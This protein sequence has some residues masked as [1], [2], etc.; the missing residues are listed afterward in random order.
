MRVLKETVDVPVLVLRGGL[1][2]VW[3]DERVEGGHRR[4]AGLWEDLT[5][6]Q[7]QAIY[8]L[9]VPLWG[10][11][12]YLRMF[13]NA[14]LTNGARALAGSDL[15]A[16]QERQPGWL[17]RRIPGIGAV[18]SAALLAEY[19]STEKV[20]KAARSGR[21]AKF[22]GPALEKAVLKALVE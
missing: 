14:I 18:K 8:L 1:D 7:T 22:A 10:Y 19:G 2:P 4:P 20:F 17:L 6:L 13:R 12:R 16:P 11:V 21:L 15:R 3:L 9:P 5:S